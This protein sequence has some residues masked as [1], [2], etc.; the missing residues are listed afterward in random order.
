MVLVRGLTAAW[1][2]LKSTGTVAV[3]VFVFPLIT[4]TVLGLPKSVT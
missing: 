3:I 2:G 1:N 4:D